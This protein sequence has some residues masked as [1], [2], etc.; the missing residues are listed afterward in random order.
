MRKFSA[1]FLVLLFA[2]VPAAA[3][4]PVAPTLRTESVYFHCA[5]TTKLAN[6]EQAQN[7]SLP[8]WNTTAPTQSVQAGA[9]CGWA[10]TS[11]L[12]SPQAGDSPH[13]GAWKGSYTGNLSTLTARLHSISAGPGRAGGAQTFNATLTVDGVSMFGYAADGRAQ[14]AAIQVT[15]V[16]SSTQASALYEFSITNLPFVLEEGD[17]TTPHEIILNVAASSEPLMGW[18]YDTTEVPSGM[19]FNPATL[20][21]VKVA[22]TPP[23][24]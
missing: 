9:G 21:A 18:V 12:R 5:G 3:N 17:G 11:A 15:P 10:D 14:R 13:D 24:L 4:E 6:A 7:G 8:S 23:E 19:T 2:A 16:V 1:L 20:A 22:A